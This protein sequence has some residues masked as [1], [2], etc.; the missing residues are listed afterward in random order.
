MTAHEDDLRYYTSENCWAMAIALHRATGWP[1]VEV[2]P[3][4]W[5]ALHGCVRRPDGL[6][7]DVRGAFSEDEV[8][9][10]CGIIDGHVL[11]TTI[12]Q[13]EANAGVEDFEIE[14]AEEFLES[15]ADHPASRGRR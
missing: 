15:L 5:P 2:A 10:R 14:E 3:L 12:E 7:V 9:R 13:M 8:L 1:L 11:E 6:L 4:G